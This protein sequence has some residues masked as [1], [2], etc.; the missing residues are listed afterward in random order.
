MSKWAALR[1][2]IYTEGFSSSQNMQQRMSEYLRPT[3]SY[4]KMAENWVVE[5]DIPRVATGINNRVDR[6][7]CLGNAVVPQQVYPI[8]KAIYEIERWMCLTNFLH[9]CP[10]S[11]A[12]NG[13]HRY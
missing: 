1:Q 10:E 4:E 9:G 3:I 12:K 13:I 6:L 5:P 8:L 2:R 7:K 11:E